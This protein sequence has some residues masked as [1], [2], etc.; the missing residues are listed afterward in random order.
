VA[1][2]YDDT[3]VQAHGIATRSLL[4]HLEK[5]MAEGQVAPS[6]GGWQ[7]LGVTT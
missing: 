2:A 6:G 5:L 4:A 7:A 1:I 3:P